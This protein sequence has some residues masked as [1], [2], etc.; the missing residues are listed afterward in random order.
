MDRRPEVFQLRAIGPLG[1]AGRW[2]YVC[3]VLPKWNDHPRIVGL[4]GVILL[5]H[6][7]AARVDNMFDLKILPLAIFCEPKRYKSA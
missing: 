3:I 6:L 5:H 1:L 7:R 4:N 2:A